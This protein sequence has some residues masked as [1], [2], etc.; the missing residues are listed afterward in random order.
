VVG[1]FLLRWVLLVW[2]GYE[3]SSDGCSTVW[4]FDT[5]V[6]SPP[7]YSVVLGWDLFLSCFL[8]LDLVFIYFF[9]VV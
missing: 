8:D 4:P 9:D 5:D 3:W 6:F 7:L 1:V 2:S